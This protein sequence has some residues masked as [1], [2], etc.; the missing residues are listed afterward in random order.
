MRS[1]L[2]S[3]ALTASLSPHL[4]AQAQFQQQFPR[5]AQQAVPQQPIQQQG[6]LIPANE[7][8]HEFGTVARS[9]K[10]E[11]RFA[12]TNIYNQPL[13]VIA[14]RASCGCTTPIIE[15]KVIAPG[16][17]GYILARFNTGTH[18][19]QKQATLTVTLGKPA[20][21]EL[22]LTVKGYI[23]SDIVFNPGELNFGTVTEG[24]SKMLE[25]DLAYAGRSDWQV[26]GITANAP[27]IKPSIKE[28][29]RG[30]GQVAYKISAELIGS[31]PAGPLNFQVVLQTND[32]R[33]KQV[34]IAVL[35]QVQSQL[36]VN[37]QMLSLKNLKA[38]ETIEER[39]VLKGIKPFKVL[40]VEAKDVEIEFQ[41]TEEAKQAHII[42]LRIKPDPKKQHWKLDC[43][44]QDGYGKRQ[45][46]QHKT[47]LQL[48][49]SVVSRHGRSRQAAG[50]QQIE[51]A[52]PG[53]HSHNLTSPTTTAHAPSVGCLP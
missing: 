53:R 13:E 5:Q 48:R 26:L 15:D 47:D 50:R 35:G 52:R 20:H 46:R 49:E 8:L 36:E 2:L 39:F 10:T 27:F 37:P 14:V 33:L 41:P 6:Q 30:N 45:D 3:C 7:T 31:A 18:T 24:E 44:L 23:R 43:D 51:L 19:G 17:V 42:V 21:R 25:A 4:F 1:L 22:Q 38:G 16:Q 34:P 32:N 11:H 29:S 12:I 28:V 9:A 40:E